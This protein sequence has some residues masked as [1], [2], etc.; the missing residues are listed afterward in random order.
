MRALL[1]AFLPLFA[2]PGTVASCQSD[3]TAYPA[4][5]AVADTTTGGDAP[6]GCPALAPDAGAPCSVGASVD[7]V[8]GPDPYC[9][10]I[11]WA[12]TVSGWQTATTTP[13][14]VCPGSIP[15]AG[16]PCL[17][18]TPEGQAC[19]F[20]AGCVA[21]CTAQSWSLSLACGLPDAGE[22]S[23]V[24]A[25]VDAVSDAASDAASDAGADGGDAIGE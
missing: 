25:G 8:Y 20:D 19:P 12:C 15:A 5:A 21:T 4:D 18:C 14:P 3:D 7:C 11:A 24:D 2:L 13:P 6:S 22:D 10:P 16:T 17:E 9:H 1:L 23:A